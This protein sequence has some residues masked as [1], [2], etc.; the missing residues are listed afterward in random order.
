MQLKTSRII[1]QKYMKLKPQQNS[2]AKTLCIKPIIEEE[3]ASTISMA[4]ASEYHS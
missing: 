2:K 3:K 1:K 4:L